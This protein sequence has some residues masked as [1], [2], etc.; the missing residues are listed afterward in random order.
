MKTIKIRFLEWLYIKAVQFISYQIVMGDKLL[1]KEH[2]V[3][4]GWVLKDGYYVEPDVKDR[5]MVSI[6]FEHH[7]Y[8]VWHGQNK[9]FIAL[10]SSLKWFELHMLMLENGK[11]HEMAGI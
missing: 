9:T 11:M 10:R 5:D 4:D 2:L 8:R 7:Y 1:T 3:K 6:K